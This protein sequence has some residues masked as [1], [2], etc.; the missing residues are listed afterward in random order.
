MIRNMITSL[1]TLGFLIHAA[2]TVPENKS[3]YLASLEPGG[4]KM[5]FIPGGEY[6]VGEKNSL[7]NSPVRKKKFGPFYI[8]QQPVT[9]LQFLKFVS[10]SGYQPKG[11]I[12]LKKAEMRPAYPV[13]GI[14]LADARAYAE[15]SGKRLPSEWEWEIAAR[16]LKENFQ[17]T[18][19]DIYRNRN[20]VFFHMERKDISPVFSTPPNDIGFYDHIGNIFEWTSGEYPVKYLMGKNRDRLKLGVLRGGSWTNIRNDVT[21]ATRIPFPVE[22]SLPWLG[23]RCAKD[24]GK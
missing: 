13:T 9:N 23:F 15:F 3:A 2:G 16:A 19:G 1:L 6:P 4:T 22:R 8:D 21:Y 7:D 17:D 12:D 14:T 18:L 11:V 5:I 10:R 24:P 20:G